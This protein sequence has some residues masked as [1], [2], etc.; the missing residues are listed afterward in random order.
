MQT[1]TKAIGTVSLSF[2]D[3]RVVGTAEQLYA[4]SHRAGA[5]WPCSYL[6][7]CARVCA[8]LD[9]RNGDLVDLVVYMPGEKYAED[10]DDVDI[11]GEELTAWID[12]NLAETPFAQLAH[13]AAV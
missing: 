2:G 11:P 4:W 8:E 13:N 7:D 10:S 6:D 3:L 12:D 1:W 9:T 5:A